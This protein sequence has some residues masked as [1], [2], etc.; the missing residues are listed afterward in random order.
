MARIGARS[1][2]E[3]SA[4]S[5]SV[6]AG[7]FHCALGVGGWPRRLLAASPVLIGVAG[8]LV[9]AAGQV[10]EI[11]RQAL[12][13]AQDVAATAGANAVQSGGLAGV[14]VLSAAA[15]AI[16]SAAFLA[17]LIARHRRRVR[18]LPVPSTDHKVAAAGLLRIGPDGHIWWQADG[19]RASLPLQPLRWYAGRRVT[20]IHASASPGTARLQLLLWRTSADDAAWRKLQ[21]WLVWRERGGS[22]T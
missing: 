17:V 9:A 3:R 2:S 1:A 15:T 16:A 8:V 21:A 20:W 10:G 4:V 7:S 18:N 6:A 13:Q 19:R 5:R 12:Q 22:R 14:V 11:V